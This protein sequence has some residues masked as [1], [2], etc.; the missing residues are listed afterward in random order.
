M[1]DPWFDSLSEACGAK[2]ILHFSMPHQVVCDPGKIN[3]NFTTFEATRVHPAWV[4][5]NR[6]HDALILPT[7]S[8]KRAWVDSGFPEH[9]IRLCPYGVNAVVF[10]GD[11]EPLHLGTGAVQQRRVRFLNISEFSPRKNLFGLLEAWILG[12]SRMD[13]AVL[14]VKLG[15]YEASALARFQTQTRLLEQH[16][17]KT[18]TDAAPVHFSFTLLSDADMPRLYKAATHYISMSHGEGWDQ[19]MMEA[20]ASGL[21]LIAPAHSAYLTYLD[22]SIAS[23]IR[24]TEIPVAFEGDAATAALFQ[25]AHW[26]QPDREHAIEY[27]RDAIEGRDVGRGSPRDRIVGGFTWANATRRLIEILDETQSL[28]A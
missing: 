1:R 14:I 15:C 10:S 8:S 26:W 20:A 7:E 18:L 2:T 19:T 16:L 4:E 6:K 27:I 13:D 17:R 12:T 5:A 21:K 22:A 25:G 24:S 28:K 23:L 11:A 3:A 9:R